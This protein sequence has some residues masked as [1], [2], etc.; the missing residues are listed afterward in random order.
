MG[1]EMC[2]RDSIHPASTIAL[3]L[4]DK[5]KEASGVCD[6]LIR[7]S[8]GIEDIDDLKEDFRAALES[9]DNE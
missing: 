5:D 1:S 2:I 7:V 4:S 6:D 9:T 8:V 3:H